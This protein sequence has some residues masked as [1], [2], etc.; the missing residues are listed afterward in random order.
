MHLE[1]VPQ[2]AFL[3]DNQILVTEFSLIPKNHLCTDWVYIS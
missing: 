2:G 3:I 1:E